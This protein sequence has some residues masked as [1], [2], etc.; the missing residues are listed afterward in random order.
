MSFFTESPKH[1]FGKKGSSSSTLSDDN[2]ELNNKQDDEEEVWPDQSES[3][4]TKEIIVERPLL[5]KTTSA[6]ELPKETKKTRETTAD[7]ISMPTVTTTTEVTRA[8]PQSLQR[9]FKI[10]NSHH[11]ESS[12]KQS[13][14]ERAHEPIKNTIAASATNQEVT[15]VTKR[16]EPATPS[17]P[18]TSQAEKRVASTGSSKRPS[19]GHVID[20]GGEI[21]SNLQRL[22][23]TLRGME[24]PSRDLADVY[25]GKIRVLCEMQYK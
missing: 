25:R 14:T 23:I 7:V 17:V 24:K 5:T 12:T 13:T 3:E 20:C 22:V 6:K 2:E 1:L 9:M 15:T 19:T 4:Q 8:K 18:S 16:K 21:E 11:Q 10:G